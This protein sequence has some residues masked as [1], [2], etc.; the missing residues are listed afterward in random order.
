V[1]VSEY[2]LQY[3][4]VAASNATG[5]EVEI[6]GQI[7]RRIET[8]GS[9]SLYH[10]RSANPRLELPNSPAQLVQLRAAAPLARNRLIAS[11]AVRYLSS[12]LTPHGFRVPPVAVADL[13]VTTHG[14]HR[15]FDVQ[16]GV[17]NLTGRRY[18]DPLSLEHLTQ[19]MPRAGRTVFL[20]LIWRHGE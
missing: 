2:I 20:K 13:T 1:P 12:R 14:L 19:V 8:S 16:F 6:N 11:T 4:N 3:R 15:D 17:R 10:A 9:F 5:L 18:A 7:T